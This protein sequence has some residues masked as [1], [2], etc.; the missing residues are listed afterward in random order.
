MCIRKYIFKLLM[1][2]FWQTLDLLL[3]YFV[4]TLCIYWGRVII[5]LFYSYFKLG[6]SFDI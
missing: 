2:V 3:F 5:I 6:F 4:C 1:F